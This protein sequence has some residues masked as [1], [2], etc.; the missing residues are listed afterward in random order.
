M[1]LLVPTVCHQTLLKKLEV[2]GFDD[3]SIK[4]IK[5]YLDDRKQSVT[6]QE[7]PQVFKK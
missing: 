2:Y 1:Y 4:W 5:S 7:S 6:I 3:K